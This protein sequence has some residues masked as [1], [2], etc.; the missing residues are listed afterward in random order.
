MNGQRVCGR[1]DRGRP[2]ERHRGAAVVELALVMPF[3]MVLALGICEL[4]QAYRIDAILCAATRAG[5]VTGTRPGCSNSDVISD[6]QAVLA[7]NGLS[8]TLV[9]VTIR[10]NDV[11]SDVASANLNDKITVT[12]SVPTSQVVVTTTLTYL[13]GN[14]VL[15]QTTTMMKQG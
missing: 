12:A 11:A 10:V 7:T 15:S 14:S 5:C 4:G 6:V 8:V 13:S 1:F 2:C 3:L 9:T